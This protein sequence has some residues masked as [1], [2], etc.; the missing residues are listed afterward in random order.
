MPQTK[1]Q[2][3]QAVEWEVVEWVVATFPNN[4]HLWEL[5]HG[6]ILL[7]TVAQSFA[8]IQ[9]LIEVSERLLQC[10]HHGSP[11]FSVKETVTFSK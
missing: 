7:R 1:S 10:G 2:T 9:S 11:V 6:V 4:T 8:F 3:F 5:E